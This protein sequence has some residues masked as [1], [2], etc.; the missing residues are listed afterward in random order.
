[1]SELLKRSF[2]IWC[3][4]RWLKTIDRACDKYEKI[5]KKANRQ[6][7]VVNALVRRY[8]EIYDESLKCGVGKECE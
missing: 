7:Y 2:E 4:K 5:R 1:M 8:N 3:K 6:A